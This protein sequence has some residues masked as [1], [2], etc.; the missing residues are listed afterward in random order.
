G[1][2]TYHY[3]RWANLSGYGW[4]WFPG[5]DLDWGPAWVSWRTGGDY[6]G[7]APLPPRG[8]GVVYSGRPIGPQV[9][10]EFDIGPEYY[11]FCEVRYIGEPVLRNYIAPPVQNVTYINN[12]VNIT[13]ITVQNNVVYN[14]GPSYEVL[15]AASARPIQRLS[16]E[17]Q[18][19]TNLSVAAKSGTLTKV[20]GNKLIVAAPP[21][22]A[23]AHP[24]AKPPAVKTKVA[25]PK[26]NRG[27]AGVPNE[28]QLKQKI[29]TE[30]PKN[31]PPPT[32]GA[33][34]GAGSP[35]PAAG[36]VQSVSPEGRA[37]ESPR[38]KGQPGHTPPG[39]RPTPPETKPTPGGPPAGRSPA[40]ERGKR[41]GETP[42]VRPQPGAK[43]SPAAGPVT[44]P[45]Q[46]FRPSPAH[47]AQGQLRRGKFTPAPKP[48]QPRR[49]ANAPAERRNKAVGPQNR[50][51]APADRG[52][53]P[54]RGQPGGAHNAA[55]PSG[56]QPGAPRG[57]KE[58]GQPG[59]NKPAPTPS[60]G[61]GAGEARGGADQD[62]GR[63]KPPTTAPLR[64]DQDATRG[65]R[66]QA[67][68]NQRPA[69]AKG[70]PETAPERRQGQP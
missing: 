18:S 29:R 31:V 60:T 4:V 67:E 50:E 61:A 2:A 23:K 64:P 7:W 11:N 54:D 37:A 16:I 15:S 62:R 12:T 14:Y 21:K 20:Q 17:R 65:A 24:A 13:N 9:D 10:I 1:W 28:A 53:R 66:Q 32:A 38:A 30:N 35:P 63:P 47:P 19:A 48:E 56:A 45:V 22:L 70:A 49:S 59:A 51:T 44:T 43:S 39:A 58:R 40:R 6:V 69:Q 33:R 34:R 55:P 68:R 57:G 41:P 8:P 27:W 46:S 26:L 25:Q 3:G 52:P 42:A 36:P 5:E